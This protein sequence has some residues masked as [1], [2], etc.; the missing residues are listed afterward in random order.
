MLPRSRQSP[1]SV[2]G[3]PQYKPPG[4]GDNWGRGGGPHTLDQAPDPQNAPASRS[5]RDLALF[6]AVRAYGPLIMKCTCTSP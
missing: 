3:G 2:A 5:G 4:S 6:H 1:D